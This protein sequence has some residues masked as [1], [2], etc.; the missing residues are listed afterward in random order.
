MTK[1][2]FKKYGLGIFAA[3]AAMAL[4]GLIILVLRGCA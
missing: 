1:P 2:G 4:W 3:P